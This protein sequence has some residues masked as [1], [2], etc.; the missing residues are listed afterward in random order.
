MRL[1]PSHRTLYLIFGISLCGIVG[2][3]A[4]IPAL[5]KIA[6]ELNVSLISIGLLITA[7][8][9]P[10]IF[11]APV[12]GVLSDNFGRKQ[13]VI[14]CLFLF[15]SAGG[16]SF[17]ARDFT[18]LI[19][20]RFI[21]GVGGSGLTILAIILIGDFYAGSSRVRV[22][23]V[24][25][26]VLNVGTGSFP[27][28][29]GAIALIGWNYTFLLLLLG[30]VVGVLALFLLEN[31]VVSHTSSTSGYFNEF[32]KY[33]KKPQSIILFLTA[34]I[35]FIVL[36][37]AIYTY[38]TLLLD[39]KFGL[40]SFQIGI[41]A[42]LLSFTMA[43]TASQAD[44]IEKHLSSRAVLTLG[45]FFEGIG[46]VLIPIADHVLIVI[47]PVIIFGF[48][49]GL[50]LPLLLTLATRLGPMEFRGVLSAIIY[51]GIRIGQ[52]TGPILLGF[53]VLY[54]SLETVFLSGTIIVLIVSF[55]GFFAWK[56]F[57]KELY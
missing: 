43:A 52:T 24:N 35:A 50:I 51:S 34:V 6:Q 27:L 2:N 29:G 46:L 38:F 17:F 40:N 26:S 25:T 39:M 28:I 56:A 13:V 33:L 48:G 55:I 11:L 16:L 12:M 32:L 37:G 44:K 54:S 7:F 23:G 57:E 49:F 3:S 45:F 19:I 14:P 9:L 22:M 42:S 53:V 8:T 41:L 5:P 30:V 36:Y 1:L 47:I 18:Q 20:L 21:Q 10:G 4:V 15:G 31:P